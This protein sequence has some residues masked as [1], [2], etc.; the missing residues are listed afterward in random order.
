M[1]DPEGS[2]CRLDHRDGAVAITELGAG[3]R[4]LVVTPADPSAHVPIRTWET[5]YPLDL[6]ERIV[7]VK[8][9]VGV[10][11]EI[12]RDEM[13]S[14]VALF[15]RYA[16]LAYRPESDFE[17]RRLL[18]FGCGSGAS[19]MVLARMFPATEIVGVELDG[20]LVALADAR[21]SALGASNVSFRVSPEPASLP[22][23]LEHFHF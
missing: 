7:A 16:M 19:T 4:R 21:A 20:E 3:K 9:A 1:T 13:S 23:D 12:A 11:D 5:S 2:T 15:L 17:H 10:C 6:I 14:Y 18:D 22:P 8:G